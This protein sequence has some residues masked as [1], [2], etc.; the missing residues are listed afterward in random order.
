[1]PALGALLLLAG[2]STS[3]PA[4]F[5]PDT[6]GLRLTYKDSAMVEPM[7]RTVLPSVV[8][9]G[10][11]LIP[12]ETSLGGRRSNDIIN[13]RVDDEGVYMVWMDPKGHPLTQ[14]QPLFLWSRGNGK[15]NFE[16]YTQVAT[17]LE[18]L[19]LKG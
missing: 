10:M 3:K 9:D 14:Q 11:T 1:M 19:T 18:P 13:Y 7:I 6:P 16:G 12:M 15:W 5:F 2:L 17:V 8:K 4:D